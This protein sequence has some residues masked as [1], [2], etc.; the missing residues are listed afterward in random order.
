MKVCKGYVR[1]RNHPEGCIAECYIAEEAV[2][3]L[4]ELF[5]DDKTVGIP[6]APNTESKP[7]SSATVV[8]E[9]GKELHQAHLCVLQN[10]DEFKSYF[11]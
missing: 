7:T 1:N 8:S 10:T 5:F 9:Y 6:T 11:V 2:E 4:A 3:L